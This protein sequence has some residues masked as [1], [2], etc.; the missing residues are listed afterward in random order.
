MRYKKKNYLVSIIINCH[1]GAK[2]LDKAINSIIKQTY[3]NWEI[4]FWNNKS[5]DKSEE[6]IKKFNDKRII[7]RS[8]WH[9]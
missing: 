3:N 2:Y 8:W 6:I 5:E 9:K 1:N 7:T 4:I